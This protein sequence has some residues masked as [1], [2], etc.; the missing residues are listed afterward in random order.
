MKKIILLGIDGADWSI[1]NPL[2]E[3]GTF[4]T[5][6]EIIQQGFS[7]VLRSCIPPFS[8][9]AWTS[10]FTGT[11]PGKHGITDIIMRERGGFK[12]AN[13]SYRMVPPIWNLLSNNGFRSIIVN[14]PTTYPPDR[15]NGIMTTGM[16]TPYESN[17]F[18]YPLSI[19]KELNEVTKKYWTDIP[20]KYYSLI[21][22]NKGRAFNLLNKFARKTI[23]AGIYLGQNYDWDFL[24][25]IITS[26]DRL[27]HFYFNDPEYIK[28]HYQVIDKKINEVLNLVTSEN[29]ELVIVSDHG[30]R[31]VNFNFNINTFLNRL[32]L[33]KKTYLPN[34]L[35]LLN[36]KIRSKIKMKSSHILSYLNISTSE[37][38]T[39]KRLAFAH[40]SSGIYISK[41]L[42]AGFKRKII[43]SLINNLSKIK[44][45]DG[46]SPVNKLFKSEEILHG[47]YVYRA[48]EIMVRCNEG[49]QLSSDPFSLKLFES[50]F[51]RGANATGTHREEGILIA[52]GSDIKKISSK[53]QAYCWDITPT[54]LHMFGLSIPS[55]MDG[56]VLKELFEETSELSNRPI[57]HS[58][59]SEREKV[60]AKLKKIKFK[61]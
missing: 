55:Y 57:I 56:R 11:N 22:K 37:F 6:N 24:A 46:K 51:Y 31:S 34:P 10:I 29:A 50:P 54:L 7:S 53:N 49:Y 52:Y 48:P 38:K 33:G 13:S 44:G 28:K 47:S 23:N 8:L 19:N 16:M 40:T 2:L 5:F 61:V 9:P 15:F 1:I 30:F 32:S 58:E 14:E 60:K 35:G 21:E 25:I 26:T 42:D 39:N 36:P 18:A 43:N 20:N 3:N 27:Q 59:I 12:I 41:A 4:S 45:P 17:N